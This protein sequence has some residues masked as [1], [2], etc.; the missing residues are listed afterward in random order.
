[1]ID[2]LTLVII[3]AILKVCEGVSLNVLSSTVFESFKDK[4]F[5]KKGKSEKELLSEGIQEIKKFPSPWLS[6]WQDHRVLRQGDAASQHRKF[7][8][9]H[10]VTLRQDRRES[11]S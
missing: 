5:K 4:I 6:L 7:L 3:Y 1:M 8:Y 11:A 2:P 9:I 10:N